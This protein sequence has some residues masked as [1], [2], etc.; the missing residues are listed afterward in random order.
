MTAVRH[1]LRERPLAMRRPPKAA[2]S[3]L[4]VYKQAID[5]HALV[6]KAD[7]RGR[8]IYANDKFCEISRYDRDELIGQDHRILN[9]GFHSKEF[10]AELWRALRGGSAWHGTIRNRAKDGSFYWVE[11]SIFPVEKSGGHGVEYLS[12]RTHIPDL[13][14]AK[15]EAERANRA[16]SVFLAAMSHEL[17]T[18]MNGVLGAAAIL[19]KMNLTSEMREYVDMIASS[20]GLLMS[21][22]NDILDLMK[23]QA[24]KVVLEKT[25]FSLHDIVRRASAIHQLKAVEKN[26]QFE[27]RVDPSAVDMRLGDPHKITQVLHNLLSNAV[28]FTETGSVTMIV[29]DV[30]SAD[31]EC[32]GISITVA[33]TGIG[34]P[35]EFASNAFAPFTQADSAITRRFGGTGLGLSI[36]KN[37]VEAMKGEMQVD[38]R[39]GEGTTFRITLPL[40][41]FS[42]PPSS[43]TEDLTP[44]ARGSLPVASILVVDDNQTNCLILAAFLKRVGVS[45]VIV[46]SGREAVE[47]SIARKFDIILMDINMPV[48]G[49]EQAFREI[50]QIEIARNLVPTPIIAV[51]A[52]VMPDQVRHFLDFGFDAHLPKPINEH[53]LFDVI[54]RLLPRGGAVVTAPIANPPETHHDTA[55]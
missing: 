15:D 45:P 23:F 7:S 47:A 35:K 32:K 14:R 12:I 10:M 2:I 34:M 54:S 31:S 1:D 30:E 41:V 22:L 13:Q 51:S 24:G 16:K 27:L 11:S 20:G 52:D 55:A 46:K 5:Q 33:D 6:S 42:G 18:P 4:S 3:E 39:L 53:A 37:I 48:M 28:K 38:S 9:S 29:S 40:P 36:T 50:R 8:I 49:G 25:D 43:I 44:A 19:Q 17:R 21:L 26:L